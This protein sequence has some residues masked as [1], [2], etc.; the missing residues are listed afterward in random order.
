[1]RGARRSKLCAQ[2]GD[3]GRR[4]SQSGALSCV[5]A[6]RAAAPE[7]PGGILTKLCIESYEVDGGSVPGYC[8]DMAAE[9]E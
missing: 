4:T 2:R 1:M 5:D 6:R 8:C 9:K 3:R 7:R